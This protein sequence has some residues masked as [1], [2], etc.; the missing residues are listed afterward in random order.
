MGIATTNLR[1][2]ID[3][4][5]TTVSTVVYEPTTKEWEIEV[6]DAFTTS[7]KIVVQLY[8]TVNTV[9]VAKIGSKYYEGV[10]A[11]ITPV[12]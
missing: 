4:T 6:G 2:T 9:A 8:D 3:G 10:T 1:I 12:A 11:Q 7:S 5:S